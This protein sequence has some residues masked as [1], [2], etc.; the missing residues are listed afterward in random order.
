MTVNSI[1]IQENLK[2]TYE[3]IIFPKI[4][5]Q[6]DKLISNLKVFNLNN[7]IYQSPGFYKLIFYILFF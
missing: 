4:K 2:N 6:P 3:Q 1:Y 7:K 5:Q